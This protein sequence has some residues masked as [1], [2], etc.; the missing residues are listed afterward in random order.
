MRTHVGIV[1]TGVTAQYLEAQH[2]LGSLHVHP[3]FV[4]M[5]RSLVHDAELL[6]LPVLGQSGDD[7]LQKAVECYAC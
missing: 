5:L 3:G 6:L 2:V 7:H 1:Y 4:G